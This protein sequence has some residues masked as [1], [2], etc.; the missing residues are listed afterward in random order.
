MLNLVLTI[1]GSD[2]VS[3][4]DIAI[5]RRLACQ[6]GNSLAH[7]LVTVLQD[8]LAS[9]L[10]Q[11]DVSSAKLLLQILKLH[12][13]MSRLDPTLS[14]ELAQ[15]GS[16][17]CLVKLLA[18]EHS[19]D[20]HEDLPVAEDG[21]RDD[22]CTLE[23]MQDTAGEIASY[24]EGNFP[25]KGTIPFTLDELRQRLPIQFFLNAESNGPIPELESV[26]LHQVVT[27]R[28]TAQK[29]VGFV[30]W[31][32]AVY[33]IRWLER[34]RDVII[35]ISGDL[36]SN[37]ILELGSGTGLC[38]LVAAALARHQLLTQTKVL[39][40]D[41]NK[42]VMQNLASNIKLN[43][44]QQLCSVVGLDFYHQSG[45]S[46][47]SAWIDLAGQQ[48]PPVDTIIA[49]DIICQPSDALAAA[50][51]I[52]DALRP[53]GCAYIVCANS[54][55]RFGVHCFPDA[56]R[57]M[58]LDIKVKNIDL[59]AKVATNEQLGEDLKKSCGYVEEM[60]LQ[61]FIIRQPKL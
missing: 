37:T 34:N 47:G 28:Q 4:R 22:D 42:T 54:N 9:Y 13:V 41:F 52:S 44:L 38:G 7:E 11:S 17:G 48:N 56:C 18:L 60:N 61:M 29:D 51:T 33:L 12:L 5:Q 14:Q 16:H 24:Y 20:R 21:N 57:S 10:T 25:V 36:A 49:A 3:A 26:L 40:S 45:A 32:S 1:L 8:Y 19:H 27:T 43:D 39:L 31:P 46:K 15:E 59:K 55:H 2:S 30:L 6:N 53:G 58:A 50:K 35:P 23:A